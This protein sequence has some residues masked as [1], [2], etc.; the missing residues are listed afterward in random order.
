M[1]VCLT[2]SVCSIKYPLWEPGTATKKST[3]LHQP[4]INRKS[5]QLQSSLR[6]NPD[7]SP[8]NIIPQHTLADLSRPQQT[9]ACLSISQHTSVYPS[10]PQHTSI[11]YLSIPQQIG[12]LC[13]CGRWYVCDLFWPLSARSSPEGINSVKCLVF[14]GLLQS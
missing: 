10:I 2:F 14:A 5:V 4:S 8:I 12:L 11:V 3:R 7:A 13:V 9:S 6:R 1:F